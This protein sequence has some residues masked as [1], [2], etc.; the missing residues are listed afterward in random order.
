MTVTLI[1][2]IILFGLAVYHHVGY[3]ILL[4]LMSKNK[5]EAT[6]V[7]NGP[8]KRIGILMCAYNE[9]HHISEKLHNLGSLLYD[10][11]KVTIHVYLDGCTDNT[12]D[13]ALKAQSHLAKQ[14]VVCHLHLSKDNRGKVQGI[15]ELI[16]LTKPIYDILLFTD[17][18]ALLSIDALNIINAHF[19]DDSINVITGVY[20]LD[21]QATAEQ[22][23]YWNYQNKLKSME[24]SFGAVAGVPGAMFAIR[25]SAAE[26][27][28][29]GT[30]NDDFILSM[31][32]LN[33]GGKAI[34]DQNIT[35]LE[36][37]CDEHTHDN[38]RRVRLGAGNWQQIKMLLSLLNPQLG[39]VSFNY[40]SHKVLRG[41]MPIIITL[42]YVMLVILAGV[43]QQPV[44]VV[45]VVGLIGLHGV[46][47]IKRLFNISAKFPV[48]DK[49]NYVLNAYFLALWGI[50]KFEKGDYKKHWQRVHSQPSEQ[51]MG[52]KFV[53]RTID[54]VG[55]SIGLILVFPI[56][57][58]AAIVTKLTSK[59]PVIFSQQ[60]VGETTDNFVTLF[61]VL[62][63]RSMVV[64]AEAKSGAVWASKNDPRITPVGRFMRKTR[65]DELPQLWNVLIGDMSL[66]GPRPERPVFYAKLEQEIP[67]FCQ[68]TYGIKPG[69][70]G[71]AQVMNG[72]DETLEDARNKI[73]WDYAYL[74]STSS[75][76]SWC[77]ME[78]S[79]LV[80]TFMVVFT[81]KGQ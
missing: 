40:F 26:P 39:W 62:K 80:R 22:K 58:V 2:L 25:A 32:A 77:Y 68:R 3:P 38:A 53:K 43:Y 36:R 76:R 19:N 37:E 31:Q 14:N 74:L 34:V 33:K 59:G 81:G 9:Q 73:G 49:V 20:T 35:I 61:N 15:N 56:M 10:S 28:E 67:Y 70:S 1:T 71:L 63:F 11:E 12:Y 47:F 5:Q 29:V 16:N 13:E 41:I 66:I 7:D 30:I 69:I 21:D 75:T 4:N 46:F 50:V 23:G 48:I 24:S 6:S 57:L 18:S 54:I 64:D 52:I 45:S 27:L 44:A 8:S 51:N 55:A 17:V 65:I 78:L 42:I 79:I 72:Y 60:R